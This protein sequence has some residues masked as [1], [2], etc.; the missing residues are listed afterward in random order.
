MIVESINEVVTDCFP[1]CLQINRQKKHTSLVLH[2]KRV[3]AIG[4]NHFK[5][6]PKAKEFGYL[7]DEMHSELDAYRKIP[8]H[9]LG[10][11]LILV[12]VRYNKFGQMRM[13]KPCQTCESWCKQ[14]F[15]KIYY[16]TNEGI[17]ELEF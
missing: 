12:N 11:K 17:S 7:F 9:F 5:T 3:I 6:H 4:F 1:L 2:K 16:T 10:K 13:S 8:K 14:I 15:N